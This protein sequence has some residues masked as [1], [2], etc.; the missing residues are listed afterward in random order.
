M[1]KCVCNCITF[2][3]TIGHFYYICPEGGK[4]FF[5]PFLKSALK[6]TKALTPSSQKSW[7]LAT[8]S[9]FLIPISF[10]PYFVNLWYFKLV[11]FNLTE[12]IVWNVKCLQYWTAKIRNWK[13][14]VCDKDWIPLSMEG[15]SSFSHFKPAAAT[16]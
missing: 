4:F 3:W 16:V 7:V 2:H 1:F 15:V 11:L 14:R 12:V 9:D 10:E 8:N 6:K 5:N 13:I